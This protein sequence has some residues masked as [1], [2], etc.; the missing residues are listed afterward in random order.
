[1]K[2]FKPSRLRGLLRRGILPAAAVCC[3][4]SVAAQTPSAREG[5]GPIVYDGGVAFRVWAP[6]A[7]S[8]HVAG[9]FNNWSTTATPLASEAGGTWSADVPAAQV[10]HQY[11]YVIRRGGQTLW[12]RD[13]RST[14]V[15]NSSDNSIVGN[16]SHTWVNDEF[17]MAPWNELVLYQ[18]HIGAFNSPGSSPNGTFLS[19]QFRLDHLEELGVNAIQ[20]MPI[21]EFPGD[22][23][24]GYNPADLYAP[25]SA[26]GTPQRFMEFIDEAHGRGIAVM[27][28]IVHNH[29]GPT[30]LDLWQFDGSTGGSPPN[31]GGIYFYN[32]FRANTPWG[33]TRPNFGSGGVR[34][35]IRDSV[36]HFLDTY[37]ISGFR[38]DST[39]NIWA[40]NNGGGTMLP[41]GYSMLQWINDDVKAAYPGALLIAEDFHKGDEVT[42]PTSDPLGGLG[43]DSQWSG[44]FVHPIRAALIT[45]DDADRNMFAVRDAIVQSYY[46][47]WLSRVIYTESHD[48]VGNGRRRLPSEIHFDDPGSWFARKRASLGG[49]LTLTSPGMPMLL[50]GQEFNHPGYWDVDNPSTWTIN[51]SH[52]TTYS[53]I[54]GL[55]KDMVALRT[56][57]T[58]TS[59]GLTG[60]HTNVF[61]VNNSDKVIAWHRYDQ[62]GPGDDVVIVANFSVA[63]R[64]GYR[65]GLPRA[66]TWNVVLNSDSS[67]YSSDYA[68][69]GPVAVNADGPAYDGL[70]QSGLIDI[71]G[72]S[73]LIMTQSVPVSQVDG[74]W[75]TL[76]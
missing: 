16:L 73:A 21:N 42:R 15:V 49:I 30:D 61:H 59:R 33:S 45:P 40:T 4:V 44:G 76:Y 6:N 22:Y 75:V 48:E 8:V 29:Y 23:S 1:V 74:D 5:M 35:F 32:D 28:D 12:K 11:K 26:Y 62:G 52:K 68:N 38:W 65:I 50:M 9:H 72:Y 13:P 36:F 19:A 67:T 39:N 14:R 37:R 2:V 3:A 18:V 20:L 66:G 46:P 60:P 53:G 43:F 63:P 41:D 10:N 57:A 69:I 7:E 17:E 70:G 58:G 27:M 54:F 55:Y 71:Q 51:W 31:N 34:L 56:N 25:E 24:W 64:M 47:S